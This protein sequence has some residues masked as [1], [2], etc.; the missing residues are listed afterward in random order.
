M[1]E[2]S[3]KGQ[4]GERKG[5]KAK[6]EIKCKKRCKQKD[7]RRRQMYSGRTYKVFRK[8]GK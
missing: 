2:S 1:Q 8:A 6:A 3:R 4:K 7:H 5:G